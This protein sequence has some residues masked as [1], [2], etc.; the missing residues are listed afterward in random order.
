MNITQHEI[1]SAVR[2][3]AQEVER[4]H[5]TQAVIVLKGALHFG[6]AL[7][8]EM[9][10]DLPVEF[11]TVYSYRGKTQY[12]PPQVTSSS[13][14]LYDNQHILLIEDIIDT[15]NTLE[16]LTEYLMHRGAASIR[17][18]TLLQRE[19]YMGHMTSHHH[20]GFYLPHDLFAVG[21]GLDIDQKG[22]HTHGIK[23]T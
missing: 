23:F 14:I 3:L 5:L 9:G 22:R 10:L 7:L 16:V 4:H 2:R 15:G 17:V 8:L 19:L 1:E 20:V 18:V 12:Y 6:S 11:L 13:S 21:Y